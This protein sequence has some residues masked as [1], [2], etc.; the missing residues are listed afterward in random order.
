MKRAFFE[1]C[2]IATAALTILCI[3]YWTVS[4]STSAADFETFLPI[5]HWNSMQILASNGTITI[6]DHRGSKEEIETLTRYATINPPLTSKCR[7]AL[8]GLLFQ[9]MLWGGQLDWSLTMSLWIPIV[10]LALAAAFFTGCYLRG[11]H[12]VLLLLKNATRR[13]QTFENAPKA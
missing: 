9:S 11:R 4:R 3:G 8:P 12:Q 2:A 10:L 7:W 5:G 1:W 6:N 13:A